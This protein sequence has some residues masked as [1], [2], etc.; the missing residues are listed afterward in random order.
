[1]IWDSSTKTI[2][3]PAIL[4]HTGTE[5]S[6]NMVGG[7]TFQVSL[8]K[9]IVVKNY[10]RVDT[11]DNLKTW[12]DNQCGKDMYPDQDDRPLW[13]TREFSAD[14]IR[15]NRFNSYQYMF[16]TDRV[17]RSGEQYFLRSYD[18]LWTFDT[19][20]TSSTNSYNAQLVK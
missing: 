7:I 17:V 12:F 8:D 9:G 2:S 3:F 14:T 5:R 16:S 15:Q 4:S 11:D 13:C 1:M 18:K 20:K 6:K 10:L 19:S